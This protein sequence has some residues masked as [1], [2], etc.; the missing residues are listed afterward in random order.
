MTYASQPRQQDIL[1]LTNVAPT[2]KNPLYGKFGFEI[3]APWIIIIGLLVAIA[4]FGV[5]IIF[6]QNS[7][8]I[9]QDIIA[10]IWFLMGS[11]GLVIYAIGLAL[12][13]VIKALRRIDEALKE[14]P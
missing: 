5:G 1:D 7:K 13:S 14:G 4:G 8:T 10:S 11:L 9:M 2:I 12:G 6:L 3:R